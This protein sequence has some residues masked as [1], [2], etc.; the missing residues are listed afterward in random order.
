MINPEILIAHF[1][2]I[3]AIFWFLTAIFLPFIVRSGSRKQ[4]LCVIAASCG[5]ILFGITDLLEAQTVGAIP[6]W[7]C[8]N[9]R[10]CN[11]NFAL[12]RLLSAAQ[13]GMWPQLALRRAWRYRN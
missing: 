13:R 12:G 1:N 10:K 3:E 5:F 4:R 6:A 9:R 7:L 8:A 2:K 11:L